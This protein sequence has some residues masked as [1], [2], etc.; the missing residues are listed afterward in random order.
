LQLLFRFAILVQKRI[1]NICMEVAN[2][3]FTIFHL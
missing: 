3:W 1:I 2:F